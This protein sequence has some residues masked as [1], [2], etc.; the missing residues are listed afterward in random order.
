MVAR[1]TPTVSLAKLLSYNEEKVIQGKAK[2]IQAGNFLQQRDDL[3]YAEKLRRFQQLT[4]LNGRSKVKMLHATLNFQPG[5]N[6]PDEQ[7]T[8][9]ADRYMQGLEMEDQPYLVYRHED[10]SHPHIHIVSSLIRPDGS[11]INTDRMATRLSEPTRKAIEKEFDLQPAQRHTR[12][13]VLSPD[14]VRKIVPGNDRPITQSIDDITATVTKHYQFTDLPEY[15]AIL[16][17]YNVMAE[18][19]GPGSKTRR[20]NGI[21]YTALDDHGNKISLPVMASQLPNRPTLKRLNERFEESRQTRNENITSIRHRLDWILDQEPSTLRVLA[22]HLQRD[23]IEIVSPPSNGRNP[24]DHI[25]VDHRTRTAVAGSSL[26]Q[27]YTA[28]ALGSSFKKSSSHRHQH[29]EKSIE[30]IPFNANTPQLL[31]AV[32]DIRCGDPE[33]DPLRQDHSLKNRPKL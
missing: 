10:A 25:Y 22:A 15:N 17:A 11:R 9:I 7:L 3:D 32:L 14:E 21:Y 2:F 27:A 18:T 1:I 33:T 8:A 23:G 13:Q 12:I 26:G 29:R 31:S 20:H 5:E 24:R 6:L 30:K 28:M 19:G 4:E 16:R